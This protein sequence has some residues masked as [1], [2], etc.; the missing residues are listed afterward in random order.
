MGLARTAGPAGSG[1]VPV[2]AAEAVPTGEGGT[3]ER[4]EENRP[5]A[6]AAA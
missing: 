6:S 5:Q 2:S 1:Q 4:P 3:A